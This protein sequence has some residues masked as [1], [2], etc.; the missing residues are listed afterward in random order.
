MQLYRCFVSQS[1]EF[2]CHNPLCCL[3]TNIYCYKRIFRY[4]LSPETFGYTLVYVIGSFSA[5][6]M[7]NAIM[8]NVTAGAQGN[9]YINFRFVSTGNEILYLGSLWKLRVFKIMFMRCMIQSA[10]SGNYTLI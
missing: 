5:T 6:H 1:S 8:M 7:N 3:S 10:G 2:C 4:R 9:S